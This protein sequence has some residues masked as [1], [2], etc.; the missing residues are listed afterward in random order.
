MN[1]TNSKSSFDD[2]TDARLYLQQF[3][4]NM[5]R[6]KFSDQGKFKEKIKE[7]HDRQKIKMLLG[8]IEDMLDNKKSLNYVFTA[9]FVILAFVIGNQIKFSESLFEY[10][11]EISYQFISV[12]LGA[13]LAFIVWAILT[14]REKAL[15]EEL[16]GYKRLLQ[17]CLDEVS[18]MEKKRRFP[19]L[20]NKYRTP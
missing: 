20:T 3:G 19:K 7:K 2:A 6:A 10:I 14:Y 1:K 11:E 4:A 16:N 17:E 5:H 8:R 9:F 12:Y 18:D 13:F 15:L